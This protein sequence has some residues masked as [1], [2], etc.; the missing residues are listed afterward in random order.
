MNK[1]LL[2][3]R[4]A[5]SKWSTELDMFVLDQAAS[6]VEELRRYVKSTPMLHLTLWQV[7][8]RTTGAIV[9]TWTI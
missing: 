7:T 5:L 9:E 3:D 1:N 2:I 8:D 4:Y 6:T